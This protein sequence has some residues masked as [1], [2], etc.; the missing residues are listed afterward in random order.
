MGWKFLAVLLGALTA[1][2]G[3]GFHATSARDT[4]QAFT[5]HQAN[6]LTGTDSDAG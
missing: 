4:L 3:S 6:T 2:W 1:L 5:D